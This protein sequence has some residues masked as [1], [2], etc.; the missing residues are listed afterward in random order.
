MQ[1]QINKRHIQN[2]TGIP[3]II[4]NFDNKNLIPFENNFKSKGDILMVICFDFEK[5]APTDNCFNPEQCLSKKM[6]VMSYALIVAFHPHLNLRK[7]TA[8]RR[9]GHS[10][11]QLTDINYLTNDQMKQN[12]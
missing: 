4:Y 12:Y 2:C 7:I 1:E 3:G 8:Q 9:Y 10:L 11:K 6:I 5:T